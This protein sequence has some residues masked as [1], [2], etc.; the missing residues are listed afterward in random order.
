MNLQQNLCKNM[1]KKSQR[2]II[3]SQKT[4]DSMILK[5]EAGLQR[6]QNA[7]EI[8][9]LQK[10]VDE[11]IKLKEQAESSVAQSVYTQSLGYTYSQITTEEG[12]MLKNI[13]IH[14]ISI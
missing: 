6:E 7:Q 12:K 13:K 4:L 11:L 5:T 9:K 1:L 14:F 2:L 10:E 8:E 3:R